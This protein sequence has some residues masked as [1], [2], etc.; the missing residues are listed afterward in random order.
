MEDIKDVYPSILFKVKNNIY[1]IN[2]K[3]ILSIMQL[4]AYEAVPDAPAYVTGMFLFRKDVIPMLDLRS[5][6]GIP[7][8]QEEYNSF[9]DM[10]EARIQDHINWVKELE[11]TTKEHTKFTL[12]TDPH[13]CTFGKWYYSYK[14]TNNEIAHHLKKIDAPHRNL[15]HTAIEI[16]NCD[17]IADEE[18]RKKQKNEILNHAKRE[19]MP[20]IM[21]LLHETKELFHAAYK[22]MVLVLNESHPVGLVV[23]E[24]L[25]VETLT[26]IS[27]GEA[28]KQFQNQEYVECIYKSTKIPNLI[29]SLNEQKLLK[30]TQDLEI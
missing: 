6:F 18:T 15:H 28:M 8:L 7:T 29:L 25:A 13:L 5:V 10:I 16:E 1:S 20:E 17:M 23:D 12:A 2:S 24:V 11:K 19:Y 4:P 27:D 21:R 22:E 30:F 3:N 26:K 14:P 9:T